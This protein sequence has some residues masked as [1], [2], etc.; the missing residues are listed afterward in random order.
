M[1]WLKQRTNMVKYHVEARGITDSAVLQAMLAVPREEFVPYDE[2]FAAYEDHPL[3]IAEG[4]TISQPYI[5]AL[6][7]AALHLKPTDIA[8]EIGAGSGYAAAVMSKI[9]AKVYTVERHPKLA[10]QA[11]DVLHKLGYHNVYVL[12]G[13]GTLG[14]PEHAPYN[15]ISV[16]AST[17][18][19]PHPLLEQLAI[20]GRLILPVGSLPYPQ[21]LTEVIR[22]DKDNYSYRDLGSV[23]FVP[24]IGKHGWQE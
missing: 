4:Q 13:D 1:D 14:W 19:I 3:P 6:M 22:K 9:A 2:K 23:Q 8:L 11:R 20:N 24:L 12:C 18:E 16:T 10:Q 21:K 17:P 7:I 15:A 5:V